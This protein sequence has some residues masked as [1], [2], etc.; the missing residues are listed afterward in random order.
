VPYIDGG[1][2]S[3]ASVDV[4]LGTTV[5]EVFV[6]APMASINADRGVGAI[7][8]LER[9][10]RRGITR[11]I[12]TDIAKLRAAGIRVRVVAP[13]VEDLAAMGVN[14]MNPE[15]RTRCSR[16][17]STLPPGS[18]IASW[19]RSEQPSDVRRRALQVRPL[20][21]GVRPVDDHA[22]A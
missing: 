15:H 17:R 5:E 9:A 20:H 13:E 6:L 22:V 18:C 7:G 12:L 21:E 2:A 10:V 16:L 4:L 11:G 14:L 19:R 8:R 1:T 3:N